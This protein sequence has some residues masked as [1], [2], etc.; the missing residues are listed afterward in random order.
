[1]YPLKGLLQWRDITLD[2][3]SLIGYYRY[4]ETVQVTANPVA[5]VTLTHI[6]TLFLQLFLLN[7]AR[8]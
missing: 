1:M 2:W 4:K 7:G 3:Q 6:N 8:D 5:N